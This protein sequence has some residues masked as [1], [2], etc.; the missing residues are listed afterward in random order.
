MVAGHLGKKKF[1]RLKEKKLS[2]V[3][4]TVIPGIKEHKIGD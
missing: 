3:A 2:V 1:N 4:V